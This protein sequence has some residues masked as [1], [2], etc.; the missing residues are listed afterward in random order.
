MTEKIYKKYFSLTELIVV[1]AIIFI[2]SMLIGVILPHPCGGGATREKARQIAC[3]SNLKQI[4]TAFEMYSLDHYDKL[5]AITK[6]GDTGLIDLHKLFPEAKLPKD[7]GQAMAGYSSANFEI[8]RL[9][10]ILKD[11]KIYKCPSSTDSVGD[12]DKVLTNETSSYAYIYGLTL[13]T[14]GKPSPDSAVVADAV[15]LDYQNKITNDNHIGYG[16][17]LFLDSHVQGFKGT[18]WYQK[19]NH[20]KNNPPTRKMQTKE[21]L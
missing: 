7:Y 9:E 2:I 14:E 18:K 5:P 6:P 10:G 12:Q 21:E 8:L 17:I 16:N 11:A 3:A 15:R 4:G 1:L 19:S 13:N 20:W